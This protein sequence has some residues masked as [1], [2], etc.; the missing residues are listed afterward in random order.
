MAPRMDD[1]KPIAYHEAAHAVVALALSDILC[2]VAIE[3]ALTSCRHRTR[4]HTAVTA[5][6][7]DIAEQKGCPGSNWDADIDLQKAREIA[8]EISPSDSDAQ[9]KAFLD[10]ARTLVDEHWPKIEAVA[11][12][13]L[14]HKRLTGEQVAAVIARRAGRGQGARAL[15]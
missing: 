13:L 15:K 2:D 3:P 9:L 1:A 11:G 7:G 12:A 14:V 5:L 10:R 8:V 6:A 4:A